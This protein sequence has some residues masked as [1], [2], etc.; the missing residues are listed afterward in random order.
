MMAQ[1]DALPAR[2]RRARTA[3]AATGSR[4]VPPMLARRRVE[5]ALGS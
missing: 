3:S 4:R 5:A 1:G 2:V